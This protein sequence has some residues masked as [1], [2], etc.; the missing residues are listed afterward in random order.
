MIKKCERKDLDEIY[1]LETKYFSDPWSYETLEKEIFDSS[2]T[3]Y[4]IYREGSEMIGYFGISIVIDECEIHSV[5]IKGSYQNQGYGS[6]MVRY[7]IEYC[8]L[9]NIQKIG[10]EVREFNI[11]AIRLYEKFGFKK[12]RRIENYYKKPTEDA[13]F[14]ALDMKE[15]TQD[16]IVLAIETSC[17]E[18]SVAILKNGRE[19][20]A[21]IISSQINEHKKF[22]GVVPEM[23][24]R[25]HLEAMNN[26]VKEALDTAKMT[27]QE[28]DVVSV[29]KGPGLIGALLVGVSCAK[30]LAFTLNKPLIGVNHMQ[31]HVCANYITHPSLKPPFISLVV[32]GGHTYL[33]EVTDYTEYHVIGKTRDDACGESF[34]K[35]ARALGLPYPGGPEIDKLAKEGNE[36]V[37]FFP[38]VMLEK[39]SYDFSFSGLKTNVLN[40]LNQQQQKGVKVNTADVA[41]SFQKAVL[42]VLVEKSFRLLK[43]KNQ[44][45]F[46]IS[47]GVS[48]NKRLRRMI[49][50]K[51]AEEN[52]EV[53]F[54]EPVLCTDN[55]A[56]IA[57]AG[58]FDYISGKRDG[59]DLKVYPNLAL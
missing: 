48:A 27:F 49:E 6:K 30:S 8:K 59:L 47:G 45:R 22:G 28:I 31:G 55:A 5:L 39:D 37:I 43:E 21:N 2:H 36:E 38:R 50:E 57:S 14:M 58:Y 4:F 33:I 56:M 42:D 41:A 7:I 54:P 12:V 29:T 53:Y 1:Q 32:S 16:C 23:A 17:D 9:F 46:V 25:L 24:S 10:L 20:L 26:I 18:T 34:D 3:E 13:F 35:I 51:A 11:P 15:T 44:R 52:I 19:V 40:Y